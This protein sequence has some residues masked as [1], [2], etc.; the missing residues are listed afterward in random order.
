[1]LIT[2]VCRLGQWQSLEGVSRG[3][4]YLLREPPLALAPT[5]EVTRRARASADATQTSAVAEAPRK[6]L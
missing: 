2:W 6:V 4:G 1:M 3:Q 5:M